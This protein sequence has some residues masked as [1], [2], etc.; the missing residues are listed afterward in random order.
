MGTEGIFGGG[1]GGGRGVGCLIYI[2]NQLK[3]LH[4]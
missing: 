1:G 3:H 4:P 2:S